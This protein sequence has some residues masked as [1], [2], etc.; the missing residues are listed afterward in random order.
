MEILL[1]VIGLVLVPVS[2]F[3]TKMLKKAKQSKLVVDI[4]EAVKD[5]EITKEELLKIVEDIKALFKK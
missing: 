1:V 5:D 3:L 4:L 2:I